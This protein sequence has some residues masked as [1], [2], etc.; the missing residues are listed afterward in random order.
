M[1]WPY[2]A[3]TT[4]ILCFVGHSGAGKT[5]LI[6]GLIPH[7]PVEAGRVAILKQSHHTL[8]WHPREKDSTRFWDT[9]VVAVGVADPVPIRILSNEKGPS[10]AAV[11]GA[12]QPAGNAAVARRGG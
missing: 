10:R 11:G 6:E 9:G 3:K 8:E 2:S 1:A 5:T 12:L 7:L 4:R